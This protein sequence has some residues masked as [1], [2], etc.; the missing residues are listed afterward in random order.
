MKCL[1]P[2]ALARLTHPHYKWAKF[3]HAL[4]GNLLKLLAKQL[5]L[6]NGQPC[7]R[8][9]IQTPP[10]HA[11]SLIASRLFPPIVFAQDPSAKLML[12]S[13]GS[14]LASGHGSVAR[15]Y[16]NEFRDHIDPSG[17]LQVRRDSNAKNN[18]RTT[19]DGHMYSASIQGTVTGRAATGI[20]IDDPFKGSEDS[21]S[22]RIRDKVWDTYSAAAETR[23]TPDGFVVLIG[24]PWHPDDLFGRLLANEADQWVRLRFPA[25]AEA[26]DA[27]GRAEGEG[28]FLSKYSQDWYEAK[29]RAFELRGQSHIWDALYNCS[30]TGDGSLR[31]FPD[32]YFGPWMWAEELPFTSR[33]VEQFRVLSLD[34]SKSKTGKAGDYGAFCDLSLFS[35]RHL[36]ATMHLARE[37]LPALYARAVA[38]V[39]AA[40]REGRP[41]RRFIIES[42]QFQEAVGLAI[43]ERLSAAGLDVPIDLHM[44]P[45]DQSKHARI[46]VDLGPL[47]AQKRLHFVGQTVSNKLTL[48]QMKEIPNGAHDDGP[49]AVS[50]ATQ[51]LNLLLTGT[52]RPGE[53]K[54]LRT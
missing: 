19:S 27:L 34:P 23:L 18:W 29:K 50:M 42:N 2:L 20:L 31:A 24:T 45:S 17:R 39:G 37:P 9:M 51:A 47:L 1:T 41:Y 10:Q 40:K 15:D 21:G 53:T 13:Y 26:D 52:K 43:Q 11:K 25:I 33:N 16:V 30:P 5:T 49:D 28:L 4:Q 6:P 36:F 14:E 54:V 38:I 12:L 46:Q 22:I 7:R 32:E 44:T 3:H 48:Q 8:L 35:D